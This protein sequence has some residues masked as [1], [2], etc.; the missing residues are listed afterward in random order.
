MYFAL[1]SSIWR[2]AQSVI[3]PLCKWYMLKCVVCVYLS[4]SVCAFF[5]CILI[6]LFTLELIANAIKIK[7]WLRFHV[8]L[9]RFIRLTAN[10]RLLVHFCVFIPTFI[11]CCC[12]YFDC[13]WCSLLSFIYTLLLMSREKSRE[14]SK[15]ISILRIYIHGRH[16]TAFYR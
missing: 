2:L 6:I 5:F 14:T 7:L 16:C 1:N 9:S 15:S 13:F 10:V 12:C 4:V 11:C 3:A 8:R